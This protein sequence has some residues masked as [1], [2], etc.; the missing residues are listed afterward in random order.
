MI[1]TEKEEEGLERNASR[2][3]MIYDSLKWRNCLLF[4]FPQRDYLSS[5]TA[6]EASFR[7]FI[8]FPAIIDVQNV[9]VLDKFNIV[10]FIKKQVWTFRG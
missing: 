5:P 3:K 7:V 6:L 4:N 2:V 9:C 1:N 10:L 8:Q